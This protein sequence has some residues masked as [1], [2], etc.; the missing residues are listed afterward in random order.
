MKIKK[1]IVIPDMQVPYQDNESLA[2]VEKYMKS[3]KFDYYINLG[4]FLD[5][6]CISSHNKNNLRQVE[7]KR[8]L[9]DYEEANKI[10]DRHQKIV[11]K[12]NPKAKF[13]LLEGNHEYRIERYIDANPQ[14]EGM[15]E[16]EKGLRLDERGFEYIRCCKTGE[17]LSIGEANFHHGIY[18]TKYHTN[19]MV[20]NFGSNI[21]YGHTHD[22]MSFS[23][24]LRGKDQTIVGQ[25][26]GCLCQYEQSYI[27]KNP[28]N[29]QQ[30]FGIFY[31]FPNGFFTYY[32]P[33]IF[34]GRFV[35]PDGKVF[36]A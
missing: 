30:G 15:V 21:F 9:K 2:A 36:S 18:T 5:L 33:R 16:V 4:D 1:A 24:V 10:L 26:L 8:I 32:T 7:G 23:K 20:E 17:H 29:W 34:N 12:N 28:T 3:Q 13:Y 31:F 19:K 25:S 14:L 35:A 11:R 6:D 22:I 27:K